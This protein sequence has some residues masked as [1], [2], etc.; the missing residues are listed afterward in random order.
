VDAAPAEPAHGRGELKQIGVELQI[1]NEEYGQYIQGSFVGRFD[2]AS[3]GPTPLFTEIDGY[4]YDFFHGGPSGNRS[5]V[6]DTRLDI[7]LEAQRRYTSK[8][9]GRKVIDEIQTVSA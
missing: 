3:W 8:T 7:L 2:E 4:L 5:H 1:V 6:A 9:S